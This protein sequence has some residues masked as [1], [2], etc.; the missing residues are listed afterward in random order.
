MFTFVDQ[1]ELKE[2][3]DMD[4]SGDDIIFANNFKLKNHILYA[5]RR[6][7]TKM[8]FDSISELNKTAQ[9]FPNAEQVLRIKVE[10]TDAM[11]PMGTKFAAPEDAI[12]LLLR[13]AKKLGVKV[14]G[15]SFHVGTNTTNDVVYEKAIERARRVFDIAL[16][17]GHRMTLLDIGGG[18]PSGYLAPKYFEAQAKLI[19]DTLDE[20]FPTSDPR[21]ADLEVIA[22]PGRYFAGRNS[23]LSYVFNCHS[24][25]R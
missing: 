12:P 24:L 21:F 14:I 10:N 19:S 22:E 23:S 9:L 5:R 25:L 18:F 4:V 1:G 6:G 17:F 16:D 11:I 3:L 7:V 13:T 8:T 20:L 2:V 15:L